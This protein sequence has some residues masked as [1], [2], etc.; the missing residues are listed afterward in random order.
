VAFNR[1]VELMSMLDPKWA[2]QE[3]RRHAEILARH[4]FND[5]L[6]R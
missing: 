6:A 3:R 4:P 2:E 1:Q 5:Q